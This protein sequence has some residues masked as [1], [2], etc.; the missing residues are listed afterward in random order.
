MRVKLC[1]RCPYRPSDLECHYDS[2]AAVY[3]CAGCDGKQEEVTLSYSLKP[4]RRRKCSIVLKLFNTPRRSVAP[5]VEEN[6]VSSDTIPGDRPSVRGSV[7]NAS[8]FVGRATAH[9]CGSFKP[10]ETRFKDPLSALFSPRGV[11]QKEPAN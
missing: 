8:R 11:D 6:S 7:L 5:C 3:A 10:A 1:S 9:G 4:Y 2:E